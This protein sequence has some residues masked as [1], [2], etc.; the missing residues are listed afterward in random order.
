MGEIKMRSL[1]AIALLGISGL[2]QAAIVN[3]YDSL[4]A[5]NAATGPQTVIDFTDLSSGTILTNQYAA[6]GV[7]FVDGN[8]SIFFTSYFVVDGFGVNGNGTIEL[9]FT[10]A[11]NS[12]GVEF[13]GAVQFDLY[14][15]GDL[16]GTSS[17]FAG[18]GTGFFGG[19][20]SSK[21]DRVIISDFVDDQVYIDNLHFGQ[22]VPIPAAV[23]LFGSALGLL[24]W[25]KRK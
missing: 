17:E 13:P 21:F 19:V 16:V 15:G 4:A 9:A 5:Y 22:V 1:V 18:V 23:W 2:S 6:L 10:G 7:E 20:T 8:D 11:M 12:I 24:G 25:M 3:E 14:L